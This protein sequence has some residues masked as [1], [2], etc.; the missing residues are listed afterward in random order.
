[1]DSPNPLLL[2]LLVLAAVAPSSAT[3]GVIRLPVDRHA[4]YDRPVIG[5]VTHPG[6]GIHEIDPEGGNSG[7]YIAAS[8]VKFVESAGA[9]V[10]PLIY[11]DC[12][13]NLLGNLSLVNGV[14]FTGGSKKHGQY[15]DT[16]DMIF[17]H[18]KHR[19]DCHGDPIPLLAVCLGFELLSMNVSK[20]KD[21]LTRF[22][23]YNEPSTLQF[24]DRSLISGS[25]FESFEPE[26]ITKLQT[27][28]LAMQNH[29]EYVSTVQAKNYSIICTQWHPEKAI[30]EWGQGLPPHKDDKAPHSEDAVRVTQHFANYFISKARQS[31]N[32]PCEDDV[33]RNLIDSYYSKFG[34][35]QSFDKVYVFP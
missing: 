26:L 30:F 29:G 27:R 24:P 14:L 6:S 31:T 3:P 17:Q 11:D 20:D 4:L 1:M 13:E 16:I 10:I 7:S 32:R 15:R 18:V 33:R 9:R 21:I 5:I 22:N 23:A 35:S 8:Y 25:V 19:K 34:Q 12:R 28:R 2:L